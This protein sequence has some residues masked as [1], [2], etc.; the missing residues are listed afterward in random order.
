MAELVAFFEYW[1]LIDPVEKLLPPD[2][3]I[4]LP[5]EEPVLLVYGL[6][7]IEVLA[8][9]PELSALPLN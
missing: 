6:T 1:H 4:Q 3:C 7:P 5:V 9:L 8:Q 2:P